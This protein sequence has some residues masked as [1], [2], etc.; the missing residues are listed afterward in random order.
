[1]S[2]AAELDVSYG[3]SPDFFRLWLGPELHYTC[4]V[5]D[6]NDDLAEA[7][8]A[9]LDL[10]ADYAG[11]GPGSRVLD[12]GCGWGGNLA[13]LAVERK[14]RDVHGITLS[15]DQHQEIERR[16]MPGVTAT[17]VDFWDYRPPHLFDALM[18]ICMIEHLCRPEQA[19][20]DEAVGIY[21]DYFRTAWEWTAP[22]ARFALQHVVTDRVPRDPVD[23]RDMAWL[24]HRIF[25]G[26]YSPR[27]EHIVRAVGPYWEIAE[28]RTR[29]TDYA[30]TLG[31]W[32]GRLRGNAEL[33]RA[34][35]GDELY[36]DYD[37][38]LTFC[39][40]AFEQGYHSLAQWSLRRND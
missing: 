15:R 37:R 38:Y 23:I 28:L 16:G 19:R 24:N 26:G 11:V 5:F 3:V 30:R 36:A 22:G 31:H 32:R 2:T 4:A 8:R 17:C 18:S 1:M 29:R 9:K 6:G 21:R 20:A 7:Q 39:I 34:R 13:H 40:H 14:V 27:L 25:P 12:I 10:L 35:W 33:I